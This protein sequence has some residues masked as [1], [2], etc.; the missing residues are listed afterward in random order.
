MQFYP[1]Q[2]NNAG[3]V[4]IFLFTNQEE[5]GSDTFSMQ[6]EAKKKK[7]GL[8]IF[9]FIFTNQEE[10]RVVANF[11]PKKIIGKENGIL[12]VNVS[13]PQQH[14]HTPQKNKTLRRDYFTDG[15]R[16]CCSRAS[17]YSSGYGIL[18]C[19]QCLAG[20]EQFHSQRESDVNIFLKREEGKG[21]LVWIIFKPYLE[22]PQQG[23]CC[24][25]CSAWWSSESISRRL[26][27]IPALALASGEIPCLHRVHERSTK[28]HHKQAFANQ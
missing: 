3:T 7:Q 6:S 13:P 17:E 19:T 16:G 25:H 2:R 24:S 4:D 23:C 1:K 21:E 18:C 14:T 8:L 12:K 22:F 28:E 5:T 15:D 9:F 27:E 26:E 11:F 10:T 20:G